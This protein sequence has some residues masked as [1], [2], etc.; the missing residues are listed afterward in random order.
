MD[1]ITFR[2]TDQY[3]PSLEEVQGL[4]VQAGLSAAI[5]T[6]WYNQMQAKAWRDG[7]GNKI[8]NWRKYAGF[9]ISDLKPSV[10]VGNTNTHP[11]QNNSAASTG[12]APELNELAVGLAE[13]IQG[14][15]GKQYP[16]FIYIVAKQIR[17]FQ[18]R[19]KKDPAD[20]HTILMGML[21]RIVSSRQ[22]YNYNDLLADLSKATNEY[23]GAL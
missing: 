15:T 8:M 22:D 23:L 7:K 2:S 20:V 6:G 4:F 1:Y 21:R 17:T 19:L 18:E 14:K 9:K 12:L 5:G 16:A 11:I 10:S 3:I 13:L